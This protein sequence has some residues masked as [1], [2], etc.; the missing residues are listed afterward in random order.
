MRFDILSIFPEMFESLINYGI[1]GRAVKGG[2]I[3]I[4]VVNIRDYAEGPHLMTDDRPFGGGDGMVMKPEPIVRALESVPKATEERKIILL[5]PQGKPFNQAI[6]RS[7]ATLEQ[8]ILVCG[9]YEGVDER[10]RSNYVDAEL[11]IGDYILTGGEL[12]AMIVVDAVCR[13]IPGV[14]GGARSNLEESFEDCFLEYPHYTRPRV[15]QGHE[16]PAV[17]LSGDHGKIQTWRRTQ[18]MKRTLER[19]PDLL[20]KAHLSE[21]DKCILEELRREQDEFSDLGTQGSDTD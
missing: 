5:T 1:I 12:P 8:I 16:V 17:L 3:A 18:S 14:L 10:V 4:N 13:L 7:L 2:E 21:T 6:A 19:R 11:S 9:R 20:K 15:F